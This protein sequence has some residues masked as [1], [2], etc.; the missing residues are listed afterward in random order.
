M[1]SKLSYLLVAI[2]FSTF[3]NAA[4]LDNTANLH[5]SVGVPIYQKDIPANLQVVRLSCKN[6][7]PYYDQTHM[8][9]NIEFKP[10][11]NKSWNWEK[12]GEILVQFIPDD[13][14][15]DTHLRI[16][17][18]EVNQDY[19]RRGIATKALNVLMT[20]FEHIKFK[21]FKCEI[22]DFN[23]ESV[24]LFEKLG[25]IKRHN[26][27]GFASDV[28]NYTLPKWHLFGSSVC[29]S[30]GKYGKFKNCARCKQA[31]YC[32][33]DCQI[34]DWSTHKSICLNPNKS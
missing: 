14:Y 32:T 31:F 12:V 28:A 15:F 20:N 34:A 13:E 19:R 7:A 11:L 29:R 3:S 2:L 24:G 16:R 10:I 25:F 5:F 23:I 8:A 27:S 33:K 22:S 6:Q 21:V 18:I 4:N 17:Y 9:F 26:L 1:L 30:C